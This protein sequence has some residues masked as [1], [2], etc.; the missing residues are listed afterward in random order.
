MLIC[1]NAIAFRQV[2]AQLHTSTPLR[3]AMKRTRIDLSTAVTAYSLPDS[4]SVRG[5]KRIDYTS[6]LSPGHRTLHQ[7]VDLARER[8][9][10]VLATGG[11]GY[12]GATR[13]PL[14]RFHVR[15]RNPNF[16][17]YRSMQVLA[18]ADT[19]D[20]CTSESACLQELL[21]RGGLTNSRSSK[22]GEHIPRCDRLIYLYLC[23]TEFALERCGCNECSVWEDRVFGKPGSAHIL[24]KSDSA[25]AHACTPVQVEAKNRRRDTCPSSW[26]ICPIIRSKTGS[27]ETR[28][29]Q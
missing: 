5:C 23:S 19:D 9:T 11:L 21:S 7:V 17:V 3:I 24:A 29:Q 25:D 8:L 18:F 14:E 12:I 4:V 27:L 6:L 10:K 26:R 2:S 28:C 22:G 1:G 16:P 13:D 15:V 20:I